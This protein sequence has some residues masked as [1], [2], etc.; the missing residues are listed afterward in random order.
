M[1]ENPAEVAENF[2]SPFYPVDAELDLK[3]SRS[4]S[5]P[6]SYMG[7]GS[8]KS[9]YADPVSDNIV[10]LIIRSFIVDSAFQKP[11]QLLY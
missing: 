3:I 1:I 11:F 10:K 6:L 4:N 5:S 9:F 8:I 7:Q 2:S